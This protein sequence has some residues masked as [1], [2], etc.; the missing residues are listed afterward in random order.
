MMRWPVWLGTTGG[1]WFDHPCPILLIA[2]AGAA[3]KPNS[4]IDLYKRLI[5][6]G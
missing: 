5:E 1:M 2:V 4:L 6:K 3:T